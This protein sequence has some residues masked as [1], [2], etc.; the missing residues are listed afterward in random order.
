[1]ILRPATAAD[2]PAIAAIYADAVLN[3]TASFENDPPA[4]DEMARRWAE[5][6]ARGLPYL[7]AERDGTVRGYAYAGPYRTRAAYRATVEDSVYVSAEARG[8]GI[9]RALLGG[10]IAACE[11]LDLR[12]MI[13]VISDP[14]S[15]ASVALHRGLG[16]TTVGTLEG[17]GYKHGRWLGTVLM[18]RR[19]GAG[20]DAPPAAR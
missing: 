2:M 5:L 18:Q 3:G 4:V 9:G 13:A 6:A 17:V 10:V 11:A 7:V 20:R 15:E 8:L 16:F 14:G 19:L 1:M 12:V